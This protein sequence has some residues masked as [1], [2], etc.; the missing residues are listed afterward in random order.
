MF[1]LTTAEQV[2]AGH[3]SSSTCSCSK[4]NTDEAAENGFDCICNSYA[5]VFAFVQFLSA[6][7]I[8]V[9]IHVYL[10]VPHTAQCC[11]SLQF[12]G[13]KSGLCGCLARHD[14]T[15]HPLSSENL[16]SSLICLLVLIFLVVLICLV[17]DWAQISCHISVRAASS[18]TQRLTDVQW[19]VQCH[20]LCYSPD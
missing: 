20:P 18:R 8:Q 17:S 7:Y 10:H 3:F 19:H 1:G 12:V 14:E 11:I 16:M 15:S 9:C 2:D 4:W 5:C 6:N 13:Q